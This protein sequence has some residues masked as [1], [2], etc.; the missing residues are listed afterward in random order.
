MCQN[1]WQP[2]SIAGNCANVPVSHPAIGDYEVNSKA[3]IW[4]LMKIIT[5]S[6]QRLQLI[7]LRY[8]FLTFA[9]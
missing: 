4:E 7:A 6:F 2:F 1:R 8:I 9:T 5:S 3:F